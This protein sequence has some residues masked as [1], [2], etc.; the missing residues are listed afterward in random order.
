V[1][2]VRKRGMEERKERVKA[3]RDKKWLKN[4]WKKQK[5]SNEGKM[6]KKE[7]EGNRKGGMR[8]GRQNKKQTLC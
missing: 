3:S 8:E 1:R 6:W 7:G 4:G 5:R 2:E